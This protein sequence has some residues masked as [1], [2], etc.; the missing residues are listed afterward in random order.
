[1][2]TQNSSRILEIYQIGLE[3][4]NATF[5]TVVPTWNDCDT[6]HLKHSRFIYLDSEK[7]L[8]WIAIS[9]VSTRNVDT[10]FLGKGIGSKLMEKMIESS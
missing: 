5:E 7:I 2:I 6:K 9:L 8:G 1:M 3:T 10:N 4:K